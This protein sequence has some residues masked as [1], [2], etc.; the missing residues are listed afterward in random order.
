MSEIVRVRPSFYGNPR[1]LLDTRIADLP[2][3]PATTLREALDE[4]NTR[5]YLGGGRRHLLRQGIEIVEDFPNR[6][7]TD[8][9]VGTHGWGLITNGTGALT[10]PSTANSLGLWGCYQMSTGTDADG[11]CCLRLG[12]TVL[13]TGQPILQCDWYIQPLFA[14]AASTEESVLRVGA[15]DGTGAAEPTDGFYFEFTSASANWVAVTA[16]GGTR[17]K[18]DTGVAYNQFLPV[19][20]TVECDG[21]GAARFLIDDVP[22][23][24]PISTNLPDSGDDYGPLISITKTTGS[25]AHTLLVDYCYF[26]AGAT[27]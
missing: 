13:V 21:A 9:G 14:Q 2:I 26:F 12:G 22:V 18:T 7:I 20:L 25:T 1:R 8:G 5:T 6:N 19:R 24:G 17:T 4:L 23:A 3:S 10:N 15:A 11:R 16:D 27:R